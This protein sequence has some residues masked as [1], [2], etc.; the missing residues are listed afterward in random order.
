M[1][2]HK[3]P[4]VWSVRRFSTPRQSRYRYAVHNV[5]RAGLR[6]ENGMYG[7]PIENG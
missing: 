7:K 6:P 5:Y 4:R 2:S 1:G 3:Y